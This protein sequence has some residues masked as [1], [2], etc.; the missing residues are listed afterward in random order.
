MKLPARL[1]QQLAVWGLGMSVILDPRQVKYRAPGT[2]KSDARI[3]AH[4]KKR[5]QM[6]RESR[7]RNRR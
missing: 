3:R 5:R 1:I 2:K 4:K 7:R 6:A